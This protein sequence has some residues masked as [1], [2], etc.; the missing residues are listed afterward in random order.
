MKDRVWGST[1]YREA[2]PDANESTANRMH[3]L[4]T[5]VWLSLPTAGSDHHFDGGVAVDLPA[6]AM[7]PLAAGFGG[8]GASSASTA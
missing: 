7:P 8:F 3:S 1:S 5:I 2:N 6:S 4:I